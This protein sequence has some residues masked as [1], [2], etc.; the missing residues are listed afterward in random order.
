MKDIR[1]KILAEAE[2]WLGTPYRNQG[3]RRGVGCDCLGLIRGI[4]TSVYGTEPDRPPPYSG[5][6]AEAGG[7]DVLLAAARRHCAEVP[8]AEARPGD[9]ILFRWRP[10]LPAKHAGILAPDQCFIHAYE[11][12][13]V[14]ASALVPQWR[15]RITAA[16]AFPDIS[17]KPE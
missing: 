4:W 7:K 12:H 15:R 11:G 14:L 1:A 6:W 2:R 10:H 17:L 9:L 5:D 16:F 13:A 3:Y 8:V